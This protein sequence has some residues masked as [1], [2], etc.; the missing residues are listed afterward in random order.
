MCLEKTHDSPRFQ[1]VNTNKF[2]HNVYMLYS[3][4]AKLTN[5]SSTLSTGS[6]PDLKI[7][8]STVMLASLSSSLKLNSIC[9]NYIPMD[10]GAP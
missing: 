1:S 6:A 8:L 7:L 2:M 10:A 3:P 4:C 5:K 9:I